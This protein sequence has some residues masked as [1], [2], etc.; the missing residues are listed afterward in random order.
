MQ[1]QIVFTASG[2][3]SVTGNFSPGDVLRCNADQA[4]HFVEEA[5]CARYAQTPAAAPDAQAADPV[6]TTKR[7]GAKDA[8]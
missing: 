8:A 7:K 4:R 6:K 3:S 5:R 2:S 1:V